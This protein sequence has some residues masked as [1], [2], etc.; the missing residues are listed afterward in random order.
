MIGDC[1]RLREAVCLLSFRDWRGRVA[2]LDLD[3]ALASF[4]IFISFPPNAK[5]K[6]K[7][8]EHEHEHV[9]FLYEHKNSGPQTAGLA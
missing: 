3:L 7:N 1:L 6:S 8:F 2:C 9:S 4:F 5:S